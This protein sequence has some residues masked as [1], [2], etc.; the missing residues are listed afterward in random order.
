MEPHSSLLRICTLRKD[1]YILSICVCPRLTV[2]GRQSVFCLCNHFCSCPPTSSRIMGESSGKMYALAS[3][4][5]ILAILAVMLRFCSRRIKKICL[6]WDD[7][8][9]TLALV[10]LYA[11]TLLCKTV[12][13]KSTFSQALYHRYG[14]L[15]IRW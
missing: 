5:N 4:L 9:I 11:V 1:L 12:T 8:F 6:S 14:N 2:A 7:Y 15:Y 13:Y 10:G 3:V